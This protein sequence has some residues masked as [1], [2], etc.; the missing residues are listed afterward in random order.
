MYSIRVGAS[1]L[2]STRSHASEEKIAELAC[3]GLKTQSKV[4]VLVGGLGLGFTLKAALAALG[5]DA[6]VV[7]AEILPAV[8]AWNSNPAYALAGAAMR[9]P[10][11]TVVQQDVT[12]L[13]RAA[14]GAF[15]S[16]I[17]DIDNGPA[18]LTTEGNARLYNENGLRLTRAA[19]K[20]GGCAA[21][22]SAA[23]NVRF[24][25]LLAQAGFAVEVHRC[26][27]HVNSG[28][29]HTLFLARRF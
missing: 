28:R 18:A 8:I 19:L 2:M 27:A 20:P 6:T 29:W 24:E 16:I 22:W 13:I 12:E 3:T 4:R 5:E 15:D 9:D 10:R 11:V 1:E 23:P 25:K 21:F 14:S 17:L 26:R 7:T